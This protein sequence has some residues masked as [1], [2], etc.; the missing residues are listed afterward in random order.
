MRSLWFGYE[1]GVRVVLSVVVIAVGVVVVVVVVLVVFEALN[2]FLEKKRS[3]WLQRR[4]CDRVK[5]RRGVT[6]PT[7]MYRN[8]RILI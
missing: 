1:I 3:D 8:V 7:E 6:G 4:V 5:S 2:V